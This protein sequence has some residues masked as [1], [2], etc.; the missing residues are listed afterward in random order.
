MAPAQQQADQ[1]QQQPMA[2]VPEHR[3]EH[4]DIHHTGHHARIHVGVGNDGVGLHQRR[5]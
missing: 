2:S 1:Q 4:D 5:E 3:A